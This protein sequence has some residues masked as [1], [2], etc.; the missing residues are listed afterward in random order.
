MP[1]LILS[2]IDGFS[3]GLG[4]RPVLFIFPRIRSLLFNRGAIT[5]SFNRVSV[6]VHTFIFR[7]STIETCHRNLFVTFFR[8]LLLFCIT[9]FATRVIRAAITFICVIGFTH[10][11]ALIIPI[12]F[13]NLLLHFSQLSS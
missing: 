6:L 13:L 3:N 8:R 11:V 10:A 4:K 12:L 2:Y 5:F 9:T 1:L 7:S